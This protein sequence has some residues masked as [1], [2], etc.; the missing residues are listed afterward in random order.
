MQHQSSFIVIPQENT[1][2]NSDL[3][4]SELDNIDNIYITPDIVSRECYTQV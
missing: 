2:L 4:S 3:L 1:I